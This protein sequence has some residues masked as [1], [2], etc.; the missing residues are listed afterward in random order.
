MAKLSGF[1]KVSTYLLKYI[2]NILPKLFEKVI[3]YYVR[4][5]E[6]VL[7]VCKSYFPV[8]FDDINLAPIT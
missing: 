7:Y 2:L 4:R 3:E 8:H 6:H 1:S 5:Y